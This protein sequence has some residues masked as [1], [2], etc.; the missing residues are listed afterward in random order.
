M[1]AL[2]EGKHQRRLEEMAA[3]VTARALV[4]QIPL[5]AVS[6]WPLFGWQYPGERA[7]AR[8]GHWVLYGDL[9]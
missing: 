1:I 3:G 5:L 8:P 2:E 9:L 4:R 6:E 7:E